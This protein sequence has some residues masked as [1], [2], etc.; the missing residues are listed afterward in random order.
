LIIVTTECF[1][2]AI[3][4]ILPVGVELIEDPFNNYKSSFCK[5]NNIAIELLQID[6]SIMY[7]RVSKYWYF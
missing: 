7:L 3:N 2:K 1:F 5:Y 6:N 4:K